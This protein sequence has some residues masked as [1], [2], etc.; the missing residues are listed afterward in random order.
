MDRYVLLQTQA[1]NVL[2][3]LNWASLRHH[4]EVDHYSMQSRNTP[5]LVTVGLR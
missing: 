3:T 2:G 5:S 4:D 1:V